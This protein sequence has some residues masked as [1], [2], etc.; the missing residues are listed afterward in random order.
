MILSV[1][2]LEKQFG[3]LKAI[4]GVSFGIREREIVSLIGSNGAGKTTLVNLISGYLKPTAGRIFFDGKDITYASPF[5][6]VKLGIGRSFQIVH[7]F[8]E[9]AVLENVRT[10]LFARYGRIKSI[11]WPADSYVDITREAIGI[12]KLFNLYDKKDSPAK[13]LSEGEK[14]ILDVAMAFALKPRL[15]LLDEPT[16]GVATHDKFNVMNTIVSAIRK[17]GISALIIEHDMDIVSNYS[18]NVLVIHEGRIMAEG[19]PEDIMQNKEVRET[20]LGIQ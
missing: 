16:S 3:S 1:E 13:E 9:A 18:D 4:D 19:K 11:L 14:K 2:K 8:E 7:L 5:K 12:L 15:L 10:P 6:R 20:I 17:E